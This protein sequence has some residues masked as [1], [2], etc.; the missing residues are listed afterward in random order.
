MSIYLTFNAKDCLIKVGFLTVP[1]MKIRKHFPLKLPP[2]LLK[3]Y[4]LHLEF[5]LGFN[6]ASVVARTIQPPSSKFSQIRIVNKMLILM[7][8]VV[9]MIPNSV[10]IHSIHQITFSP[11]RIRATSPPQNRNK[12]VDLDCFEQ[13]AEQVDPHQDDSDATKQKQQPPL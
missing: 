13:L 1:R 8:M 2:N 6:L 3:T 12:F 7:V 5:S 10:Q 4:R 9:K 11:P